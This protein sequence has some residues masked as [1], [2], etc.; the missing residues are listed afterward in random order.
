[1]KC[2]LDATDGSLLQ[3][4]L[5]AQHVLGTIMRIISSIPQTGHNP[6]LHAKPTT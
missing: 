1:M 4:L 2:Q 6:Q 3:N 5:S